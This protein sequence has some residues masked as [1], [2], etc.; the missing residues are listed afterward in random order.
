MYYIRTGGIIIAMAIERKSIFCLLFSSS[1]T[2]Q[3][4][5]TVSNS[6]YRILYRGCCRASKIDKVPRQPSWVRKQFLSIFGPSHPPTRSLSLC[7]SVSQHVDET[8]NSY[9]ADIVTVYRTHV[10]LPESYD[11]SCVLRLTFRRPLLLEEIILCVQSRNLHKYS[12]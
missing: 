5:L 12:R 10:L 9:G 11:R 8:F 1:D 4:S 6:R 7:H 3:G 2:P